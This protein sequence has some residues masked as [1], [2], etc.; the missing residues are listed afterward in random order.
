MLSYV[1]SLICMAVDC[2]LVT[3]LVVHAASEAPAR[4]SAAAHWNDLTLLNAFLN[5]FLNARSA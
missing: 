2:R 5:A 1:T 4:A 3:E